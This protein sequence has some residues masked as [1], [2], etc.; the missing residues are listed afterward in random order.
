VPVSTEAFVSCISLFYLR[1]RGLSKFL[2]LVFKVP[3][4]QDQEV[5][6]QWRLRRLTI[7]ELNATHSE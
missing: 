5:R 6:S 3:L 1:E 2:P 4:H 7:Y